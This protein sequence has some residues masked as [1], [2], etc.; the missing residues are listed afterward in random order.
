MAYTDKIATITFDDVYFD[1]EWTIDIY[2]RD[3]Y[4]GD[5][6]AMNMTGNP[7]QIRYPGKGDM[8]HCIRGSEVTLNI[9]AGIDDDYDWIKTVDAL[10]YK[11]EILKDSVGI[12]YGFVLPGTIVEDYLPFR[13][14]SVICSDH[15]GMLDDIPFVDPLTGYGYEG[16]DVK[17]NVIAKAL[18]NTNL[19]LNIRSMVNLFENTMDQD[20]EDDPLAWE[21][22]NQNRFLNDELQ[23]VSC[24]V[25][26]EECL[27]QYRA[28]IFQA[29]GLW[30]IVRT[31]EYDA[32]SGT[33]REFNGTT[34][35]YADNGTLTLAKT[36]T[37]SSGSPRFMLMRGTQTEQVGGFKSYLITEN[38][39]LRK[40]AFI[41]WNFP[42]L[43]FGAS[44]TFT[45]RH[46][47][48]S[49]SSGWQRIY[50]KGKT[51]IY[52]PATP[53]SS[54]KYIESDTF[55]T[56]LLGAL[57]LQLNIRGC[58]F[59][60]P[61]KI[62]IHLTVDDGAGTVYY[63]DGTEW[64]ETIGTGWQINYSAADEVTPTDHIFDIDAV[65]IAGD[66][67][68]K[69]FDANNGT[70]CYI[71]QVLLTGLEDEDQQYAESASI[72]ATI[73]ANNQE[74]AENEELL[75][76][77]GNG[78]TA[79]MW[80]MYDGLIRIGADDGAISADWS[81]KGTSGG[82]Y[83]LIGWMIQS[84]IDQYTTPVLK[85]R[86]NM[87]GQ[88]AYYNSIKVPDLNDRLFAP[89]DIEFDLRH[90]TIYG[91]FIEVKT[92]AETVSYTEAVD[93][94]G[95]GIS[96]GAGLKSQSLMKFTKYGTVI[97]EKNDQS[98]LKSGGLADDGGGSPAPFD[99]WRAGT[100]TVAAGEQTVAFTDS[101]DP[102]TDYV[103]TVLWAMDA[104]GNSVVCSLG[105]YDEAGFK[106]NFTDGAT[107]SYIA[108]KKR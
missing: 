33:Y 44:P 107:F 68:I 28:R 36:I 32:E 59:S 31:T 60:I 71:E 84:M 104:E 87:V 93:A 74:V 58:F 20:P 54:A 37:D 101:F 61:G 14:L 52:A 105:D 27:R 97:I 92:A 85:L 79:N 53:Y 65:P 77:E 43:E 16:W 83:P 23:A 2:D 90:S 42:A 76:S 69:I 102:G 15:L 96:I 70:V 13:T 19:A 3:E 80:Y 95:T 38:Y 11:V 81:R 49:A 73:S 64:T 46:W 47:T 56:Q 89:D 67:K 39:G 9:E 17:L 24:R 99:Q 88:M 10:K 100:E 22:I 26:L 8:F 78:A 75:F 63:W 72:N 106:V 51:M 57:P 103:V 7:V 55:Y 35:I 50:V 108:I 18:L 30:Y 6:I 94:I 98:F 91:T 62:R 12:W 4:T 21:W 5:V 25:V 86:A 45:P 48:I 66:V 40:S 29:E 34:W 41:G 82:D 1:T